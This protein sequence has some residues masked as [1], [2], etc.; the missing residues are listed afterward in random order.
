MGNRKFR[1][2]YV[3]QITNTING[4]F[5]IGCHKTDDMNDG[6]MGSGQ[7]LKYAKAKYGEQHFRKDILFEF[8]NPTDMYKKERELVNEEFVKRKDTYNIKLG[9]E[10]GFDHLIGTVTVKDKDGNTMRVKTDDPRY[11]SGELVGVTKNTKR[12]FLMTDVDGNTFY[13]NTKD[14]RYLSGQLTTCLY[15]FTVAIDEN[16]KRIRVSKDDPRFKS[17]E[18]VGSTKGKISVKD[19]DGN[20]FQVDQDDPRYLNGELVGNT[21]GQKHSEETK[22]KI[23]EAK[24]RN[25]L[26]GIKNGAFGKY[27]M[28]NDNLNLSKMVKTEDV[29]ELIKEGW[30][31]GKT[32]DSSRKSIARQNKK[33]TKFLIA[34]P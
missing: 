5:Y 32:S 31:I 4:N 26:V 22:K 18:L 12:I 15:G 14:P 13:A 33:L 24:K 20:T 10:G 27:W 23:K 25:P 1:F 2:Y 3:Y 17:G 34:E 21:K 9:G 7:R 11:L 19:Q 29:L 30:K 8:T 6:Y 16:G 28:H